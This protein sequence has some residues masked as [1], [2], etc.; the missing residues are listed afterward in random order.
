MTEALETGRRRG[1]AARAVGDADLNQPNPTAPAPA[2]IATS[3]LLLRRPEESDLYCI[4]ALFADPIVMRYAAIEPHTE[5]TQTIRWLAARMTV[6]PP[7]GEDL[8][9]VHQGKVVGKVG[10]A[11][12]PEIGFMLAPALWGQ[13][14][15][16]EAVTASLSRAFRAHGLTHVDAVVDPL[17]KASL[18]LLGRLGF[19]ETGRRTRT[20]KL[21]GTWHDSVDLQL[22]ADRWT[23]GV[24]WPVDA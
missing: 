20:V 13:G 3:R 1:V 6:A 14:L 4:H 24:G 12:F 23:S 15:M 17:N 18:Q 9:V 16:R 2:E 21:R 22:A 7:V 5:L 8:V 19:A 10:F 11:A